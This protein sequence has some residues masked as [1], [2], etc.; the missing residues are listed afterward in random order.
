MLFIV[1]P[2]LAFL[3][4]WTNRILFLLPRFEHIFA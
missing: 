1:S 2:P 4:S 3:N